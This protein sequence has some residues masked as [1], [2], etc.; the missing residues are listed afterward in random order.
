MRS[1]LTFVAIITCVV[2]CNFP[3]LAD[4]FSGSLCGMAVVTLAL[5]D[6]HMKI[7]TLAAF[8]IGLLLTAALIAFYAT[9]SLGAGPQNDWTKPAA[10]KKGSREMNTNEPLAAVQR[11][12]D[13]FNKAVV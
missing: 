8:S 6:K 9:A 12:I 10:V 1:V 4:D 13:G 2:G 5:H 11:Y 3:I 7:N